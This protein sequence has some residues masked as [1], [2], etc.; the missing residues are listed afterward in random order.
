MAR[1]ALLLNTGV[2]P[3]ERRPTELAEA[4]RW[5]GGKVTQLIDDRTGG[6]AVLN[7]T[8]NRG[9]K[10]WCCKRRSTTNTAKQQAIQR[11]NS[12]ASQQKRQNKNGAKWKSTAKPVAAKGAPK[13]MPKET[14]A[15]NTANTTA[16]QD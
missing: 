13:Q 7:T 14:I 15:E 8:Q 9:S 12:A 1:A 16:V 2:I 4:V 11:A 10:L 6:V 3:R 5:L